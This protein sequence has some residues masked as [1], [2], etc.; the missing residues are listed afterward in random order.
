MKLQLLSD[1]HLESHPRFHAEPVPG[2]DL[3]VLAG[4]VGSYQEGSRLEDPDFGLGRFSPKKGWPTPVIYVPGNHEYDNLDFDDTHVR[5][6]A[7]CEELGILWLE[8]ET[9]VIEGI[10]FIGTTLWADFDALVTPTDGLAEALKKRGKAMR[11]ADFYLEKMSSRRNG[12]P[13]L[14]AELREQGL[15]CQAWLREALAQ[16]FDGTTVAITHFA[17]SLASADP[18]YGLTP[19]TAGFC[20][21]LDELLPQAS[22]WLHGHLHCAFDYVKDGCRVVAN[23]LGY[24]SKGEQEGFRPELLIEVR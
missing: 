10:R 3:L 14:S 7:L 15:T 2:A 1:L 4:D 11:A 23:P 12:T 16:P 5:L 24:R 6:R 13:F 9:L 17:P 22:L 19:G 21:S 20:N 18:R 8:R